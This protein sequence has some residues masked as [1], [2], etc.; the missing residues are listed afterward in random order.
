MSNRLYLILLLCNVI[1]ITS[2][3]QKLIKNGIEVVFVK[4]GWFE[5]GG[6]VFQGLKHEDTFPKHKVYV[7][8]F[9]LGKYEITNQQF[10]NYLNTLKLTNE[11]VK[12]RINIEKR[13]CYIKYKDGKCIII[14]GYEKYPVVYISW[15]AAQEFCKAKGGRLPTEAEWEYAA[16]GGQKSS[17]YI[18]SGSNN[19]YDVAVIFSDFRPVQEIGTLKPNELGI[20]DMSGNVAEYCQDWYDEN[21]YK[22]SPLKNPKGPKQAIVPKNGALI[23][24]SRGGSFNL[25]ENTAMNTNRRTCLIPGKSGSHGIRICYDTK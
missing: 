3:G 11:Q 8:D 13:D 15:G 14:K 21:Y 4:G 2:Y 10:C 22:Y 12:N 17:G 7:S 1:T 24:S 20:Y 6:Q 5:M 23:K 19:V 18:Y 25:P 9:Y 16:K